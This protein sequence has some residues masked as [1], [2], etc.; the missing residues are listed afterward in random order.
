MP[1]N[2][3]ITIGDK[4]GE[5]K[6]LLLLSPKPLVNTLELKTQTFT[7]D[8]TF[9]LHVGE[10][11][12]L[13]EFDRNGVADTSIK[14]HFPEENMSVQPFKKLNIKSRYLRPFHKYALNNTVTLLSTW[15]MSCGIATYSKF[16]KESLEKT[17][18]HVNVE[19]VI[20]KVDQK[21]NG[22]IIHAQNEFGIFPSSNMLI[23]TMDNRPKIV[24]W[25]T[26]FKEPSRHV[27]AGG[28]T[29]VEYVH[30][31]DEVYDVHIVHNARAKKWL[32]PYCHRPIYIIPHGSTIWQPM[33]KK[34]A[35]A[36]LK[37]PFDV[38]L[39]F[40]FGFSAASKGLDEL[41]TAI[42]NLRVFD[43]SVKLVISGAPHGLGIVDSQDTLKKLKQNDGL[44]VLGR[45]LSEEEVNLYAEAADLLV[46]NYY[47]PNEIASA[48]GAIHRI[49]NAG[50]PVV[51]SNEG[52]TSDLEDGINCLKYPAGD[53]SSLQDSILAVLE[54]PDFAEE[55]GNNARRYALA[56]SWERVAHQH[57]QI[58]A[59][60]SDED[61]FFGSNYYGE[62][63]YVG[64][65]G[66]LAY[67][68][69]TGEVKRW[70]YYN[71]DGDWLGAKYV[72]QGVQSVL[73]PKKMLDVGCG[74]G[75]FTAYARDLGVDVEGVDFSRWA[76]NHPFKKADGL[77]KHGDVRCLQYPDENFDTLFVTDLMEHLYVE[78]DLPKALQEI[79]RVSSHWIFYNIGA[80]MFN[81]EE[82]LMLK[83]G[84]VAPLKWQGTLV[85]GHVTVM[86]PDWWRKQVTNE[87]W[88]LR[89]DLV[90]QFRTIVPRE[91]LANWLTILIAEKI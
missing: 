59:S 64:E 82:T 57:G 67:L 86:P 76:I 40:A 27:I 39:V 4:N 70:S 2:A 36:L 73:K 65:H 62:E 6:G 38:R 26:V 87:H 13:V 31:I 12:D 42:M 18:L 8:L 10:E 90:D 24:T 85:A 20:Q 9:K 15:D 21:N 35:R 3:I 54:E 63:Y 71:A 5:P 72:M 41:Q 17:G 66:G 51:C 19:R 56:T 50:R 22:G 88:I 28:E 75:T 44:I 89:D 47:N 33:G 74:R 77:I 81:A 49:L 37:L 84:Q 61:Y 43:S 23:A 14:L 29:A 52:R 46:F 91:V 78:D 58:Y 32:M 7:N 25:H 45:Y 53:V 83:K 16:L 30:S 69:A 60:L 1:R 34:S 68:T 80:A 79:Q 48:S 55:L 11:A